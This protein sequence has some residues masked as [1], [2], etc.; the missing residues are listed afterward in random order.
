MMFF[1]EACDFICNNKKDTLESAESILT[2]NT[3]QKYRELASKHNVWLSMGGVHEKV[4]CQRSLF[5]YCKFVVFNHS[6]CV[7]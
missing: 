5:P 1:P 6:K 4:G 2:G 7:N 3:V